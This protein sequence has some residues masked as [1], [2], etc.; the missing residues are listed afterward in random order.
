[1]NSKAAIE[2]LKAV[3][4]REDFATIMEELSGTTVYFPASQ[5]NGEWMDKNERN[6]ALKEDYYSG[7]YEVVDLAKKYDLSISRVYRIVQKRD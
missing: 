7:K 4:S 2:Y 6:T 5:S 1:M 3:L